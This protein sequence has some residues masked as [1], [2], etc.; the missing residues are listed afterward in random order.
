M[1]YLLLL[2]NTFDSPLNQGIIS[3]LP[4]SVLLTTLESGIDV[5]PG[6]EVAPSTPLKN[7]HIRILIHFYINQ[8]IAV[9]FQYVFLNFF[10]PLAPTFILDF[11]VH[12]FF[13]I[14]DS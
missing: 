7:F 3:H 10:S 12:N 2:F 8:G 6:I 4:I 13:V 9:I 11:R 5:A 1:R 14:D